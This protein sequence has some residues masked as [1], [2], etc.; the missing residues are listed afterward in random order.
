MVA[1]VVNELRELQSATPFKRA[2]GGGGQG[3]AD[4]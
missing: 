1:K 4:S 2:R 3:G